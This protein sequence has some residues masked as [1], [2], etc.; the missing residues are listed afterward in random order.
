LTNGAML[1]ELAAA[2]EATIVYHQVAFLDRFSNGTNYSTRAAQASAVVADAAPEQF[3]AFT[4]ALFAGQPAENTDGL[5][6]DEIA[7]IAVS[8]GVPQAVADTFVDGTFTDW[9]EAATNQATEDLER[10]A[11]PTILING[12]VWEGDWRDTEALRAAIVGEDA[13]TA[14]ADTATSPA[15]E[16]TATPAG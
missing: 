6:D 7:A 5:S 2:G 14:P 11:T 1:D 4:A 16:A 12:E 13:A 10:P 9:V 8:V 15:A 3:T